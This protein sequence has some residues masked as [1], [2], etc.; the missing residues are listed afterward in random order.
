MN[1][2]DGGHGNGG[3]RD[4][5]RSSSVPTVPFNGED[6]SGW[7]TAMTAML[8]YNDLWDVV[9][10]GVENSGYAGSVIGGDDDPVVGDGDDEE[11]LVPDAL[12]MRKSKKAYTMLI[13]SLKSREASA[14]VKDVPTG[15][16][17]EVWR[18]LA[19]HYGRIT[20]ANKSH[21]LQ[22]FYNLSQRDG[23]SVSVY[24]ARTKKMVMDLSCV[25][26]KISQAAMQTGFANGLNSSFDQLKGMLLMMSGQ[27]FTSVSDMA[28]AWETQNKHSRS[29]GQQREEAAHSAVAQHSSGAQR[30]VGSSRTPN[31]GVCFVC[32]KSGH[33]KRE[34]KVVCPHCRKLGHS[35]DTCFKKFGKPEWAQALARCDRTQSR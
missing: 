35:A 32:N 30:G 1:A 22:A 12:N 10:N 16:A 17:R 25:E 33:T 15:N 2:N 5:G 8:D 14:L 28:L 13:C 7:S 24:A 19:D 20:Q 3:D 6:Y 31:D 26:E 23:E 9:K 34:C 11:A 21:L 27:S 29:R 4:Y 18:R